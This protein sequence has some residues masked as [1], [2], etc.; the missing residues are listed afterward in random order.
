MISGAA[1]VIVVFYSTN[2]EK[3]VLVLDRGWVSERSVCIKD[4]CNEKKYS[5]LSK[6]LPP[7]LTYVVTLPPFH[8][9]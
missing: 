9:F 1:V 6:G 4:S 2:E 8:G 3:A 5:L 7:N